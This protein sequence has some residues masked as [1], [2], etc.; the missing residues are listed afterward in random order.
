MLAP[1]SAARG[2]GYG[3]GAPQAQS[4]VLLP[5]ISSEHIGALILSVFLLLIFAFTGRRIARWEGL[6]MLS[7]YAL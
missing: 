6:L 3:E 7:A 4:E 2:F 5:L 1:Q